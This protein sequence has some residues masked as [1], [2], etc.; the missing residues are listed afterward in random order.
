MNEA[1]PFELMRASLVE[2]G[3]LTGDF[4]LTEAGNA[5]AEQLIADLRDAEEDHA[6]AGQS[7]RWNFGRGVRA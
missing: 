7:V 5:H 6:W 1:T 3:L 4:C 2:R